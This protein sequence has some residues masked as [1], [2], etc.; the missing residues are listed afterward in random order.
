[1][2]SII[3]LVIG[4]VVAAGIVGGVT[5]ATSQTPRSPEWASSPQA[6]D[7]LADAITQTYI[8]HNYQVISPFTEKTVP[9]S[10]SV[11]CC[12][13][14]G[15]VTDGSSAYLITIHLV[16]DHVK[17]EQDYSSL[18]N[19]FLRPPASYQTQTQSPPSQQNGEKFWAGTGAGVNSPY[20][21]RVDLLSPRQNGDLVLPTDPLGGRLILL[22]APVTDYSQIITSQTLTGP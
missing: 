1:M 19:S 3:G 21:A 16:N 5:Y 4:I 9:A 11:A 10:S 12:Q 14:N 8:A 20:Q 6:P 17:A 18:V 15:T 7:K 2:A 22:D 13:Y